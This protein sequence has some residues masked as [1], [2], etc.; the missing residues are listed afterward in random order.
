VRKIYHN[1]IRRRKERKDNG[2]KNRKDDGIRK[3]KKTRGEWAM[4]VR[5]TPSRGRVTSSSGTRPLFEE[6]VSFQNT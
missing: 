1:E 3:A 6:E 2:R 4:L 5:V